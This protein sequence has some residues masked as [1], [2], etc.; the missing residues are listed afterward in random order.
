[1]PDSSDDPPMCLT[2]VRIAP[3]SDGDIPAWCAAFG[4][5]L[6][7]VQ[8]DSADPDHLLGVCDGCGGWYLFA[9]RRCDEFGVMVRVPEWSAFRAAVAG[10]PSAI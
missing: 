2:V 5:S 3:R 10:D 6:E 8:P 1:M 7:L 4:G 9:W